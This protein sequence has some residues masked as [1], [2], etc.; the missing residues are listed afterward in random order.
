M[1]LAIDLRA[2]DRAGMEQTGLGRYSLELARALA[3]VR[4]GWRITAYS[5]RPELVPPPLAAVATRLPTASSAVRAAWLHVAAAVETARDRPDVWF[6]PTFVLPAWRR[7]ASVVTIHDLTFLLLPERYRGHLNARYASAATRMSGRLATRVLCGASE[8]RDLLGARLGVD[9]AKVA[10]V[11]YGVTDGFYSAAGC[12]PAG[13]PPYLLFVGTFEARKGLE[14]LYEAVRR[15]N[16][17]GQ[18]LRLV[19]AGRRGWGTEALLARMAE[20]PAVELRIGPSDDEIARL[21]REALALVYPSRM[22][23]FGLPVAEAMAA[24]CPVIATELGCIVEFAGEAPLYVP[25]GDAG[26]IAAQVER[27]LG[28]PAERARRQA[29]G[30]RVAEGLR[31]ASAG[32][33]TAQVI[34]EAREA[35]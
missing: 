19:L 4:P 12:E 34:E 13:P 11:P 2:L 25:V 21:L 30:A 32:E 9:P 31:W 3:E 17:D 28:N 6:S 33:A 18:G 7:G 29:A 14:S 22:E 24:R 16:A 8:T 5:N 26:A 1:H 10:V 15:L 35:A 23:G 27:L 20:D